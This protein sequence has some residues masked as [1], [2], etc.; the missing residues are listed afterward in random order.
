M[1]YVTCV[2]RP[3]SESNFERE[4]IITE[5]LKTKMPPNHSHKIVHSAAIDYQNLNVIH[6]STEEL[7]ASKSVLF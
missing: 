4:R 5:K 3:K 2:E 7:L 1:Q 6:E